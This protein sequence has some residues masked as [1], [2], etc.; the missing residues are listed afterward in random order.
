MATELINTTN[1]CRIELG[2]IMRVDPFLLRFNPLNAKQFKSDKI[3]RLEE[4]IKERGIIV[5]LIVKYDGRTLLVGHRRLEIAQKVKLK[6]VPCQKVLRELSQG[7]ELEF[8]IK[9]NLL[10]RH[11]QPADRLR[12]YRRIYPDFDSELLADCRGGTRRLD[13]LKTQLTDDN[14]KNN[15]KD[16]VKKNKNEIIKELAET[17]NISERTIYRDIE[18]A[19]ITK[20]KDDLMD[21]NI[22]SPALKPEQENAIREID[23]KLNLLRT[24][25]AELKTELK[26]IKKQKCK[27]KLEIKKI[28]AA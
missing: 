12:L 8:V 28:K 25:E 15:E 6:N 10:R 17:T 1:K 24:R 14:L 11:I 23:S 5:P 9:D 22:A 19:K 2:P 4:D 18:K 27:L 13:T 20:L 21:I 26:S 16:G 7:E 3:D